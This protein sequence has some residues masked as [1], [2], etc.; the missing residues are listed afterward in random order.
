LRRIVALWGGRDAAMWAGHGE[1]RWHGW[2]AA[3]T[4][5]LGG[6]VRALRRLRRKG[7]D[8]L[9]ALRPPAEPAID[10][11]L[12]ATAQIVAVQ[13]PSATLPERPYDLWLLACVLGLLGIGTIEIYAATAADGLTR[14][15][16]AAHFLER[17]VGFLAV[18][19]LAL[20]LGSRI[21]YRRLKQWTYPLLFGA[22]GLLAVTLATPAINRAPPWLP[23]P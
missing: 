13:H 20:W 18:G 8:W 5:Q 16:D 3:R 2:L 21:D 17:Q 6:A 22:L 14:F 19:G 10:P 1:H 23:L 9:R 12:P 4:A 11:T 15:H 7:R